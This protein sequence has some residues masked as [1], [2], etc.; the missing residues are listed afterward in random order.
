MS[1]YWVLRVCLPIEES[2]EIGRGPSSVR[3]FIWVRSSPLPI[4]E[5]K[6]RSKNW[7]LTDR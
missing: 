1:L 7:I 6:S 4:S 2:W 5:S 3:A